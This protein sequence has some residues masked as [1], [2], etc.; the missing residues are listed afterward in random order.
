M[1]LTSKLLRS[2]GD[3]VSFH[4][5]T[6]RLSSSDQSLIL[7][8]RLA[9]LFSRGPPGIP[10][11]SRSATFSISEESRRRTIYLLLKPPPHAAGVA[12]LHRLP[13]GTGEAWERRS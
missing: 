7:R 1:R 6:I 12:R 5:R 13:Q 3:A 9:K 8:H 11:P 4:Q 2:G 10:K